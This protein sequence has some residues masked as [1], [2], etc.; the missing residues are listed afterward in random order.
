MGTCLLSHT[1]EYITLR[2]RYGRKQ[3]GAFT[4]FIPDADVYYFG[5]WTNDAWYGMVWHVG[6]YYSY[7]CFG[8]WCVVKWGGRFANETI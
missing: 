5:G 3:G 7:M 1:R 2:R 6:E 8:F 4:H